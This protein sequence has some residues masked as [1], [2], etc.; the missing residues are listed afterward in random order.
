MVDLAET[1]GALLAARRVLQE[2]MRSFGMAQNPG[3]LEVMAHLNIAIADIK[4]GITKLE[5]GQVSEG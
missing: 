1:L 4:N 3:V 2:T 5:Q